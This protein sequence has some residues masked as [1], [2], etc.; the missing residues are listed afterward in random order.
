MNTSLRIHAKAGAAAFAAQTW[1]SIEARAQRDASPIE[2]MIYDEIGQ[3]GINASQLLKDFNA[4]DDGVSPVVV[5]INSPGGNV[6]DGIAL[7]SWLQRLGNRATVRIDGVAASAASVIACGAHHVIMAESA[8]MML[9]NPWTI[10]PGDA[11]ELRRVADLLDKSRDGLLAAYRRKA[12]NLAEDELVSMLD[13]ETWLSAQ[14]AV[15]IGFADVIAEGMPLKAC[16]SSSGLLAQY[17]RLPAQIKAQQ[18]DAMPE[19]PTAPEPV[20]TPDS[21][22]IVD[23]VPDPVALACLAATLCTEAQLPNV[24]DCLLARSGLHD[25]TRI[26]AEITRAIQVRD[27][28]LTAKQLQHAESLIRA[29]HSVEDARAQ[30]FTKLLSHTQQHIDTTLPLPSA[31][32][33]TGPNAS[34]IYAQRLKQKGT[35]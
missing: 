1:Y 12:P 35:S 23:P 20:V 6:F 3:W 10:A 34:H 16:R 28:C 11:T 13:K 17:Q 2:I 7:N 26:R 8:M 32:V 31:P 15:A 4:L 25:E 22:P 33:A 5:A 9:H 21:A 30:L 19:P 18:L 24:L 14:E 29:G 27:L